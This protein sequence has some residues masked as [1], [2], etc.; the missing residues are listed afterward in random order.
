M[1]EKFGWLAELGEDNFT[2]SVQKVSAIRN[3]SFEIY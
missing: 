2:I 1:D 3:R